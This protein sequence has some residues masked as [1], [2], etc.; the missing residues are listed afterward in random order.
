[1]VA[2]RGGVRRAPARAR[3]RR[4]GPLSPPRIRDWLRRHA[5]QAPDADDLVQEVLAVVVREIP[6]FRHDLRTGAFR[7]WLRTVTVNRL[8]TF[9]RGQRA[10]PQATGTSDF[11]KVL[12]QMEDP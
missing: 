3:G 9:W 1:A 6:N 8:R 11:E 4:R 12:D 10:R 5:L 2:R 7:R